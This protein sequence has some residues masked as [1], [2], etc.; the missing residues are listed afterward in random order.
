MAQLLRGPCKFPK[1]DHMPGKPEKINLFGRILRPGESGSLT[2]AEDA[3]VEIVAMCDE[4]GEYPSAGR[5]EVDPY[6]FISDSPIY[7]Q[8]EY[9]LNCYNE[10]LK[11]AM[12]YIMKKIAGK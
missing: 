7:T 9:C 3:H 12:T 6:D 1:E 8:R 5:V 11:A 10:R 4:C 2:P